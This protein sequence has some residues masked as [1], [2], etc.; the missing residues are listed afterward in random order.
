MTLII[1]GGSRRF[2]KLGQFLAQFNSQPFDSLELHLL[3]DSSRVL[4]REFFKSIKVCVG[5]LIDVIGLGQPTAFIQKCFDLSAQVDKVIVGIKAHLI[6]E[7]LSP[8][9]RRHLM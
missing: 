7:G 6:D 4:G 2:G 1:A 9:L 5:G 3:K 8:L